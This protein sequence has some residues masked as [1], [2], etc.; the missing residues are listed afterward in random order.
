[1]YKIN[2]NLTSTL[3]IGILKMLNNEI[4]PWHCCC[5]AGWMVT[6]STTSGISLFT[7]EWKPYFLSIFSWEISSWNSFNYLQASYSIIC[8]DFIGN[9]LKAIAFPVCHS[10]FLWHIFFFA[11]FWIHFT[12]H[13]Q[14]TML[15]L[16]YLPYKLCTVDYCFFAILYH[17]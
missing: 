14:Q 4:M 11:A 1:M 5:F 16:F 7:A 2:K 6:S 9:G 17:I 15:L 13:C 12:L 3:S 10:P 8:H